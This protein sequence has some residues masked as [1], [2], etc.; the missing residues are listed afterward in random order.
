MHRTLTALL[1][2]AGA[3]GPIVGC[4]PNDA[5]TV[6]DRAKDRDHPSPDANRESAEQNT[7]PTSNDAGTTTERRTPKSVQPQTD[8]QSTG[9]GDQP[10]TQ[11]PR[12][13]QRP[14]DDWVIF[15]AA[16]DPKRDAACRTQWL[17]RNQFEIK[18]DNVQRITV[19]MT[20]LPEG[21]PRKGPWIIHIDGQGVELTGLEP[22]PGYTG[23]KRDL[24]R[25][26]NGKW[27]V[28]K[29]AFYKVG[30]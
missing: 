2:L 17:G 26:V 19:D 12:Q 11:S 24:V 5:Q 29:D 25:S 14:T 13:P 1:I 30:T 23:F 16:F 9:D 3:I 10:D 22:R 6:S 21:A 8:P 28:D 18:T 4:Q 7:A 15:R 20:R 27:T